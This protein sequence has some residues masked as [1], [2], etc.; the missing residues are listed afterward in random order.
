MK[1]D[2]RIRSAYLSHVSMFFLQ[3]ASSVLTAG[4]YPY[5]KQLLP[6][7]EGLTLE[8]EQE[9]W[10]NILK[11]FGIVVAAY[12]L[13]QMFSSLVFG[14]VS[15]KMGGKIRILCLMGAVGYATGSILYSI[16]SVFPQE[17]RFFLLLLSRLIMG[18]CSG[19]MAL[20]KTYIATS[21]YPNER[22]E[23]FALNSAFQS[24]GAMCGPLLQAAV[25][26]L[27]CTDKLD[28]DTYIALDLY[29]ASG[30][31][32]AASALCSC[33]CFLPF[34]FTEFNVNKGENNQIY[35]YNIPK[36]DYIVTILL[37]IIYGITVFNYT[38]M[39]ALTTPIALDEFG[40]TESQATFN[41]SL[42][43]AAAFLTGFCSF[44]SMKYLSRWFDERLLY[45]FLALIP[46]TVGRLFFL[47]IPGHESPPTIA[48]LT[49]ICY[50]Y[51]STDGI[52]EES[53]SFRNV[54][55]SSTS[56][57]AP[58]CSHCWCL[59]QPALNVWQL[60]VGTVLIFG[61]HS[62]AITLTQT[63]FSKVLGPRPLGVWMGT[64]NAVSAG[65]RVVASP[66][67]TFLYNA[68]GLYVLCAILIGL[69]IICPIGVGLT[70]KRMVPFQSNDH[71]QRA[72]IMKISEIKD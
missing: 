46:V 32:S 59:D 9:Y 13:G 22:T 17:A 27:Q 55:C 26:P 3:L 33:L 62:Y 7:E 39:E 70:Y 48:N 6:P 30:W 67:T 8:E 18:F 42:I 53:R 28:Q 72:E 16:L 56:D 44:L 47:P 43:L 34:W 71:K 51:E 65:T 2:A 50:G 69:M 24:L 68:F 38:V 31:F 41:T 36:P 10:D 49:Q 19:Y 1:I 52:V 35:D 57:E 11:L 40:W 66:L 64:L 4:I 21:T 15:N 61:A 29:T 37:F 63:L 5:M 14:F 45:I 60:V 20:V 58:L 12:P 23:H 54:E 25:T